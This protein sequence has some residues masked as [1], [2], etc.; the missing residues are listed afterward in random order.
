MMTSFK[1]HEVIF[2][3]FVCVDFCDEKCSVIHRSGILGSF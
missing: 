3:Q 1:F 2:C